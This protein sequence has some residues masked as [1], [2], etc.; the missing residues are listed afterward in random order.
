MSTQAEKKPGSKHAD[1][2][3]DQLSQ[4]RGRV[5]LLDLSASVLGLLAGLLAFVCLMVVLDALLV[6][7]AATR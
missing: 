4:A 2:I 1:Y 5:R 3:R 6:Q 7:S